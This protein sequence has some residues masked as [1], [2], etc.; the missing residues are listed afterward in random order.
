MTISPLGLA[1]MVLVVAVIIGL[2]VAY[3]RH[4]HSSDL[5][6]RYGHEYDQVV[7]DAGG[8]YKGENLLHER[9]K[10]V[11]K[12]NII[13][14]SESRRS[15]FI[16]TWQDIQA[17]FVDD[18]AGAVSRADVLLGEVMQERGYPVTD[19]DQ[20]AADL[21]VDHP[22][23]V[24]NYRSGH[25]IALKH[26]RGD[27]GTEELRQAMIHYRALFDDLVNEPGDHD[28]RDTMAKIKKE[29]VRD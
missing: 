26:S 28:T 13:P 18:P 15:Q 27:A 10:R 4:R 17:R 1:I 20:C 3:M 7:R 29:R 16:G 11:A 14:L 21:S 6:A 2:V 5:R 24:Q 19:F 25:D 22:E 9:E 12:F 8:T 23:V